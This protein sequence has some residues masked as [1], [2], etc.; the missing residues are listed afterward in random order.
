MPDPIDAIEHMLKS[1]GWTRRHLIAAIGHTGR[2]SEIMNRKRPLTLGMIRVLV[3]NFK[4]DAETLIQWYPTT[5]NSEPSVDVF[6]DIKI[7]EHSA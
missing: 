4:M 7:L 1:R 6:E 5:Q 3:I 2:V